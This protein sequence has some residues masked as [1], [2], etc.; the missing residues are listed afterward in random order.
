M[1]RLDERALDRLRGELAACRRCVL[2]PEVRPIL[3][4]SRAPRAMLIGQAP[5]RS[6]VSDGRAFSGPAGRTLFRWLARAG[7]SEAWFR[8]HV[9]IAAITRCYPGPHPSGRGDRVPSPDERARCGDWLARELAIIRPA[10]VLPV[11]RLAIDRV[12]GGSP[13]DEL[14]GRAHRARVDGVETTV[15]PLP[16]P[17]GASGW[18]HA[19]GHAALLEA[20][21][22]RLAEAFAALEPGEGEAG[23]R[24]SVA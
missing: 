3:S 4:P 7:V 9:Y 1:T 16:H 23:K 15:V 24:R 12:L 5:G 13:L 22:A 6:E 14:V 8:E 19:P 11:G 21:I 2:A 10:L 18:L 17:S 20:A